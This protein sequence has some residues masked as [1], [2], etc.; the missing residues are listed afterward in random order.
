MQ[1]INPKQAIENCA[2]DRALSKRMHP[3][4]DD[5]RYYYR[6]QLEQTS[7]FVIKAMPFLRWLHTKMWADKTLMGDAHQQEYDRLSALLNE[8]EVC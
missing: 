6:D 7:R 3:D 8:S 2:N 4:R 5:H 1:K